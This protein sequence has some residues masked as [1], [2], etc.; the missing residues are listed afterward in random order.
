MTQHKTA[1]QAQANARLTALRLLENVIKRKRSMEEAMELEKSFA[2]L[3]SDDRAF[4]RMLAATTL[5]YWGQINA[6]LDKCL[7]KPGP[8]DPFEA[9]LTLCLGV[10]Q[11]LWM[12]I[13]SHAAIH[14]TVE[15]CTHVR[16]SRSKG[17]VNAVLRKIDKQGQ[18]LLQSVPLT[19]NI[20]DWLYAQWLEDYGEIEAPLIAQASLNQAPIDIT[21]KKIEEID[22]W[23]ERL[24]AL[25]MPGG[26]LRL[27]QK[28]SVED[29][30][31][32]LD[33]AWWVQDMAASLPAK[34]LGDVTGKKVLDLCAAP[35]GKTMQLAAAGAH[36]TALDRSS[37]RMRR[38][39]ENLKRTKLDKSVETVIADA[40]S[41]ETKEK[42]DIVLIDAPC[43]A[44]GTIRRHPDLLHLKT[45]QDVEKL[46]ALQAKI[47]AQLPTLLKEG[48]MAVYATCSLQKS[49]G[50][51]QIDAFLAENKGFKR[52]PIEAEVF[53]GL[54]TLITAQ[55][56][57]R[58]LPHH[59][60]AS[61]GMD[62]FFAARLVLS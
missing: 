31:G 36:V 44:T 42:F 46:M 55:G 39:D 25:Q 28:T 62:G 10:T 1:S 38:L 48:G 58:C 49:E 9:H 57:L 41:W 17:L 16:T 56:D 30:A 20:P 14:E 40:L 35:G 54:E 60:T 47:L 34:M 29:L 13:P 53:S 59:L 4:A 24:E 15:L 11:L 18:A 5:R 22:F 12:R 8:V 27:S 32:Y 6:I 37:G 21:V 3:R 61:G 50:E 23:R 26:S 51:A 52:L 7:N 45:P 43:S 19:V 33:G 2:S